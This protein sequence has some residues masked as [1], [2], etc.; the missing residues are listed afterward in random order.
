MRFLCNILS[1][2]PKHFLCFQITK[3]KKE[4]NLLSSVKW[5][6]SVDIFLRKKINLKIIKNDI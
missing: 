2:Y 5:V 3:K 4:N 6:I 1:I